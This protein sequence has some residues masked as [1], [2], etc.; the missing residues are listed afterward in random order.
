MDITTDSLKNQ[1]YTVKKEGPTIVLYQNGSSKRVG[2][3]KNDWDKSIRKLEEKLADAGVPRLIIEAVKASMSANY[4]KLTNG[5][6]TSGTAVSSSQQQLMMAPNATPANCTMEEW[7]TALKAKYEHLK[8]I[9]E[10]Q[11]PGLWL[12][13]EFAISVRCIMHI[14]DISLP[15]I[16]IILGPPS[17]NKTIA[18]DQFKGAR[19]TFTT[20][21]F[22]PKAFVS[23]VSGL[24]EEQLQKIDLLPK[25]KNKMF[26]TSEL[27][28]LFTTKDDDLANVFGIIT[29]IADGNGYF[30]ESGAQGHRGYAGPLMFVWLGAAVDI[31]YKVH[32]LLSALGPK[33]YFIRLPSYTRSQ[34]DIVLLLQHSNFRQR[35]ETVGKAFYDYL[36]CLESCP[37]MKPDPELGNIPRLEWNTANPVEKEAQILIAN[38]TELLRRLRGTVS[39]WETTGTQGL[40]YSY[41]SPCIEDSPRAATQLYN[42]ARGHALSQG[43]DYITVDDDLPLITKVVLSGAASIERVRV[44]GALLDNTTDAGY[45]DVSDLADAINVSPNTA[46]RVM[47]EFRALDLAEVINIGESEEK[48][49]WQMRLKDDLSWFLTEEFRNLKGDYMPGDFTRYVPVNKKDRKKNTPQ[50]EQKNNPSDGDIGIDTYGNTDEEEKEG[51][52]N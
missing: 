48:P 5:S 36:E 6:A 50:R 18:V 20:D 9:A 14:K 17:S 30:N 4:L 27:S 3:Y 32:K 1:G 2:F 12:P 28:P 41:S 43:R 37:D 8:Q 31:P 11:I 47:A 33:L 42:L 13:L 39:T 16:A 49:I 51:G 22:S 25:I 24:T 15:F 40:D 26:L 46:K 19:Y 7:K 10:E 35:L 44:L 29:R 45:I 34:E 23:H 21:H 38:L 52:A